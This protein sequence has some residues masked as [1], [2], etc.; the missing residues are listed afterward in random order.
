MIFR[1][2][3]STKDMVR[4]TPIPFPAMM[5]RHNQRQ[6][7]VQA[8]ATTRTVTSDLHHNVLVQYFDVLEQQL[9]S[10]LELLPYRMREMY[11]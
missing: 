1:K 6:A 8:P 9:M 3:A 11:T 10:C 7:Y 2:D 4:S 5:K